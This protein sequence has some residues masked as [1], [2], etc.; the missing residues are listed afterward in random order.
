LNVSIAQTPAALKVAVVGIG[1]PGRHLP[2]NHCL[3]DRLR[4]W[5][6]VFIRQ[7]GER[8][9]FARPMTVDA[10]TV[11]DRRYILSEG[12]IGGAGILGGDDID[13]AEGTKTQRDEDAEKSPLA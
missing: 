11:G 12:D 1:Q 9:D 7:Q 6:R 2:L 8:T 10:V 13:S 3:L 4:P 5:S